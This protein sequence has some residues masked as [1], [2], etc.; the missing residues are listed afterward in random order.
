MHI[1]NSGI[2]RVNVIQV[3]IPPLGELIHLEAEPQHWAH[4][5]GSVSS[6]GGNQQR[7]AQPGNGKQKCL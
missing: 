7:M 3:V 1:C 5:I 2:K 6:H 4:R